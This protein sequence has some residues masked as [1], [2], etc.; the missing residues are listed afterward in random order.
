MEKALMLPKRKRRKRSGTLLD[1]QDDLFEERL[2]V[3]Y[4]V[5]PRKDWKSLRR[6][7]RLAGKK[8]HAVSSTDM[9]GLVLTDGES[10]LM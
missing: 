9:Y 2:A 7:K 4:K 1:V 10:S 8:G 6:Y 5:E 3:K